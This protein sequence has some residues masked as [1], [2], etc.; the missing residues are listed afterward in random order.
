MKNSIKAALLLTVF[1]A[2]PVLAQTSSVPN[3][4]SQKPEADT[5]FTITKV[6]EFDTQGWRMALNHWGF[7]L[8][9]K[10]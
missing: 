3:M 4:G 10:D 9:F 5:P 8:D 2:A 7:C 1:A 6:A